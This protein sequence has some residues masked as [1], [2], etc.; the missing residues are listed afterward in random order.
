MLFRMRESRFFVNE[1]YGWECKRCRASDATGTYDEPRAG[2]AAQT[3]GVESHDAGRLPRFFREGEA[4]D[5][6]VRLSSRALARRF[7]TERGR[8]LRCPHCDAEEAFD[9]G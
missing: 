9:D 7:D 1:G 6:E 5:R 8:S 4:E 3:A 2:D